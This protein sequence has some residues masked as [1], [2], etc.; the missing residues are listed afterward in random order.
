MYDD[1]VQSLFT[2]F[3]LHVRIPALDGDLYISHRGIFFF[4]SSLLHIF[5]YM[6]LEMVFYVSD[7]TVK[8]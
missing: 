6:L 7:G 4:N 1:F 5:K 2:N 3:K 8:I